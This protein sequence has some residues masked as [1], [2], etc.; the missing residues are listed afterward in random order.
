MLGKAGRDAT[1]VRALGL[2]TA[3]DE[4]IVAAAA[5]SDRVLVTCDLDFGRI[6]VEQEPAVQIVVLRPSRARA[7]AITS[8]LAAFL[9]K[10]DLDEGALRHTLVVVEERGHRVRRRR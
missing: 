6:F 9:A 1:T 5:R 2:A 8:L 3:P 10:T 4:E 7:A